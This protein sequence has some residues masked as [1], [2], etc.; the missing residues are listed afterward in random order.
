MTRRRVI[1]YLRVNIH[2]FNGINEYNELKACFINLC[3][4]N[5]FDNFIFAGDFND[6]SYWSCGINFYIYNRYK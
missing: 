5:N 3:K 2:F 6:L 1:K 4:I